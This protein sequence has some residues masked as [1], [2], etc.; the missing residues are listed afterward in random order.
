[1]FIKLIKPIF[2]VVEILMGAVAMIFLTIF[3]L[4]PTDTIMLT[5]ALLSILIL[6]QMLIAN[7]LL[8][9]H[10]KGGKKK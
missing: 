3:A 1:M 4:K 8:E 6:I 7:I 10:I 9:T 5:N 2:C